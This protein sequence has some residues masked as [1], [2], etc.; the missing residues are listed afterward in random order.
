M[1]PRDGYHIGKCFL[2]LSFPHTEV[3]WVQFPVQNTRS[4]HL[5]LELLWPGSL[6]TL[7]T[8]GSASTKSLHLGFELLWAGFVAYT[9]MIRN[10]L[11]KKPAFRTR[12]VVA[13]FTTF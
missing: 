2:D 13:R 10:S 5:G 1:Q 9:A 7:Q 12:T 11:Q 3:D 6:H 8:L 4:L